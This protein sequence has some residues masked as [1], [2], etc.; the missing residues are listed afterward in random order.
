[1]TETF[2]SDTMSQ[3][4]V[5]MMEYTDPGTMAQGQF[6]DPPPATF[7]IVEYVV[8]HWC[9]CEGLLALFLLFGCVMYCMRRPTTAPVIVEAQPVAKEE[10]KGV[11]SV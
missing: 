11:I 8:I 2:Y 7:T 10:E 4:I 3:G 9:G 1:M 5:T 6:E